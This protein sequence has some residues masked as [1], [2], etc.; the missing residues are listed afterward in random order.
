[1]EFKYGKQYMYINKRYND[2]Q[3]KYRIVTFLLD[4]PDKQE[5]LFEQDFSIVRHYLP[6]SYDEV[7][8]NVME[9]SSCL[10]I[11]QNEIDSID[12]KHRR[13]LPPIY[14][15]QRYEQLKQEI[16]RMNIKLENN[17]YLSSTIPLIEKSIREKEKG[18]RR[19][20][21]ASFKHFEK[22]GLKIEELSLRDYTYKE[23]WAINDIASLEEL[24]K[25]II[26]I[27]A[28]ENSTIL[29]GKTQ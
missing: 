2:R 21:K 29:M 25:N 23:E 1:M 24:K 3:N 27:I 20:K 22:C 26:K 10:S 11:I 7:E 9:L 16:N 6:L 12:C 5:M 19:I 17:E 18:M 28:K 15:M 4:R 13:G 14:F 8:N